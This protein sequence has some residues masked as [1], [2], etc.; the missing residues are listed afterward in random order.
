MTLARNLEKTKARKFDF[1]VTAIVITTA[2]FSSKAFILVV[3]RSFDV[4]LAR[5][6]ARQPS[7]FLLFPQG[8]FPRHGAAATTTARHGRPYT[9]LKRRD[10]CML[11]VSRARRRGCTRVIVRIATPRRSFPKLPLS[12]SPTL[13]CANVLAVE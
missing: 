1:E 7:S 9:T 10:E 3:F 4:S 6:L 2:S 13:P 11:D 8:S 5:S 12:L